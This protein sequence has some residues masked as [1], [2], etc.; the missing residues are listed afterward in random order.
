[1]GVVQDKTTGR[2]R[3]DVRVLHV[4]LLEVSSQIDVMETG[5]QIQKLLDKAGLGDKYPII[6]TGPMASMDIDTVEALIKMLERLREEK[7]GKEDIKI[8]QEGQT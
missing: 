6:V 1:M 7:W 3:T 8:A 4:K 2:F 5:E